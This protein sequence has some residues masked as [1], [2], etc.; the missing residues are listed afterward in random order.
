[1]A[2]R[3]H[4]PVHTLVCPANW[5]LSGNQSAPRLKI[6]GL[7][8]MHWN[9]RWAHGATVDSAN[10]RLRSPVP[11]SKASEVRKQS[12]MIGRTGLSS[13]PSD[14]PV[15]HKDRR[16]QQ[17]TAPNPTIG[18]RGTHRPV[19]SRVSGAHRTVRCAH[20]QTE[21]PTARMLVG[22]INTPQPPPFKPSKLSTLNIQHKSKEYNP[23]THSKPPIL[24]KCHNQV[25]WSNVFSDLRE[26]D[27]C[28]IC[29]SFC[30]VAFFFL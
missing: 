4:C 3:T 11:Q 13:V 12:V 29:C 18:W 2:H 21:Q 23:K 19:N 20:R 5:P 16:L 22:A 10:G 7:S 8:G 1:M 15:H 14:Y 25:K 27:L 26:C 30:L 9:V 24:S 6:V 17:S 28:F